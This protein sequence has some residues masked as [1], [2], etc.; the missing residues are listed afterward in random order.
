MD[1][2]GP[3]ALGSLL[4]SGLPSLYPWLSSPIPL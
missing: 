1:L 4:T 3:E 2:V